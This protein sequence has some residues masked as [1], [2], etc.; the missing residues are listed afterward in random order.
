M[1]DMSPSLRD[2]YVG[3]LI[4]AGLG[5]ALGKLSEFIDRDIVLHQY[6]P[7]GITE[8]PPNALYTDD[9]QLAMATARALIAAGAEVHTRL[10]EAVCD[11]YLAWLNLQDYPAHRRAPG[12]TTMEALGRVMKGVPYTSS[13][14]GGGNES[15]VATRSVPIALRFHGDPQRIISTAA[16]VSRITHSHP[17]AVSAGAASALLVEYALSG[18]PVEEWQGEA[19]RQ[20][21]RWCPDRA[22]QTLDGIRT[23]FT[24]KDWDPEDA[25]LE[26]F[27]VRPGYGGGW[28]ANEAVGL[29]LWCFLVS[30]DDYTHAVRLGANAYGDSD[31]DGIAAIAGAISGARNGIQAVPDDWVAGLEDSEQIYGL[32]EQLW[33]IRANELAR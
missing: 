1:T 21:K 13:G 31:T 12:V 30:P 20:L 5:D 17:A 8:P 18:L 2:R 19:E 25:M 7:L 16:E 22:H 11:E 33:D 6:G 24:T 9:T 23:A 14:D 26:Q 29:A 3:C 4:G 15:I 28:A 10:M 27:R 32:A